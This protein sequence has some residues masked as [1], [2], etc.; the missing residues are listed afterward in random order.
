MHHVVD[1]YEGKGNWGKYIGW[2][3]RPF[4]EGQ[5]PSGDYFGDSYAL[6]QPAVNGF[7]SLTAS[8]HIP[9][10]HRYRQPNAH[11]NQHQHA[12]FPPVISRII[13][14]RREKRKAERCATP[15]H[16]GARER[17]CREHDFLVG[18]YKMYLDALGTDQSRIRGV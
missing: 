5:A 1:L 10:Q 12:I 15:Q 14:L 4:L 13:H 7:P 16:G 6:L 17:G 3:I 9:Q 8:E 11:S 18:V 2:I